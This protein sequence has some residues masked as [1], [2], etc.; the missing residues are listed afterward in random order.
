MPTA[1]SFLDD[2]RVVVVGS[3]CVGVVAPIGAGGADIVRFLDVIAID[4][5]GV[6]LAER[7]PLGVITVTD[8]D[9]GEFLTSAEADD[10]VA[11]L[12][13]PCSSRRRSADRDGRHEAPNVGR[14]PSHPAA[15]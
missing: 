10:G 15:R 1:V 9:S 7:N 2:R 13:I 6:S 12:R 3:S 5:D 11:D 14:E 4:L 8:F